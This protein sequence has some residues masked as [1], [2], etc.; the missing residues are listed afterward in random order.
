MLWTPAPPPSSLIL[1]QNY[2]DI[3]DIYRH[4]LC[5][6][7]CL[8]IMLTHYVIITSFLAAH[9]KER[10]RAVHHYTFSSFC[11]GSW[12]LTPFKSFEYFLY[13]SLPYC[14]YFPLLVMIYFLLITAAREK[15]WGKWGF[16][17][18]SI[19]F[20]IQISRVLWHYFM[21]RSGK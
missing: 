13:D 17:C 16:C 11:T 15:R 21:F 14:S 18:L 6:G 20:I 4:Q 7:F 12:L 9:S 1:S 5:P 2:G 10:Q 3:P 19:V 8:N